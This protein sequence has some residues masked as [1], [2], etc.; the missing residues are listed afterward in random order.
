MVFSGAQ[1]D[2]IISSYKGSERDISSFMEFANKK[3]SFPVETTSAALF[4][5]QTAN[6]VFSD[7]N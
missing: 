5:A 1:T 3:T 2:F 7:D 4:M 6:K